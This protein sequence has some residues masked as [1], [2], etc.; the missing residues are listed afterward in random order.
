MQSTIH[1]LE[2]IVLNANWLLI[3]VQQLLHLE[4]LSPAARSWEGRQLVGRVENFTLLLK[5]VLLPVGMFLLHLF[6]YELLL[7]FQLPIVYGVL[8]MVTLIPNMAH[9]N[10]FYLLLFGQ[11]LAL[12]EINGKLANMWHECVR[13]GRGGTIR[14]KSATFAAHLQHLL[15]EYQQCAKNMEQILQ[16]YSLPVAFYLL[17]LLQEIISKFFY[18]F[19][20]FYS[21]STENPGPVVVEFLGTGMIIIYIAET[22]LLFATCNNITEMSRKI[23]SAVHRLSLVPQQGTHFKETVKTFLLALNHSTL[24]VNIA[25]MFTMDYEMLVGMVVAIANVVV[26]LTQFHIDFTNTMLRNK[27]LNK[28]KST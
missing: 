19:T 6:V 18:Q 25:G 21:L 24:E 11:Q 27:A 14:E 5:L 2:W 12:R 15:H 26:F 22:A 7:N 8:A 23:K 10:H 13:C 1:S 20:F 16:L 3:G 17:L 28:S 9:V 4:K